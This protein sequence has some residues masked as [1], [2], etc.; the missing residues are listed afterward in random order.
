MSKVKTGI[1]PLQKELET[2]CERPFSKKIPLMNCNKL[3]TFEQL[4]RT[5]RLEQ[6]RKVICDDQGSFY[7]KIMGW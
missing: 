2:R 6:C 3:E 7:P 5:A 4:C 1:R